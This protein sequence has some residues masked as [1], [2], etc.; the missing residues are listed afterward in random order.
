MSGSHLL[1][2][3]G[4]LQFISG[5]R[6]AAISSPLQ[7][8]NENNKARATTFARALLLIAASERTLFVPFG[9]RARDV[10]EWRWRRDHVFHLRATAKTEQGF[11]EAIGLFKHRQ[12]PG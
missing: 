4:R 10:L 9:S 12:V 3:R 7:L 11:G 6:H 5:K 2:I 1:F 8:H